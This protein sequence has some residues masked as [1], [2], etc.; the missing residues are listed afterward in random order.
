MYR[1]TYM[2]E[3]KV[4]N[5]S[6]PL[7]G[8]Q[9]ENCRGRGLLCY[10]GGQGRDSCTDQGRDGRRVEG[11]SDEGDRECRSPR[12]PSLLYMDSCLV[13][14]NVQVPGVVSNQ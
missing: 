13:S 3:R 10:M 6:Q 1:D 2:I 11:Q 5:R 7:W 9:G 12:L 4:H 14:E 8:L